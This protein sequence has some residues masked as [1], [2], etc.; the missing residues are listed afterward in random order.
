MNIQLLT[1]S[2]ETNNTPRSAFIFTTSTTVS[3]I[4]TS[5]Q[6]P[7]LPQVPDEAPMPSPPVSTCTNTDTGSLLENEDLRKTTDLKLTK[8]F[9]LNE[10]MKVEQ[11]PSVT[12]SDIGVSSR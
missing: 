8:G 6:T 4:T 9:P 1:C 5:Q 2:S 11:S 3:P 7:K 12:T 10:E